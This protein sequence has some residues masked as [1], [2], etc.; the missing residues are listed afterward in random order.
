MK[1]LY[2]LP[3]VSAIPPYQSGRPI[4]A[5][6]R[7]FGLDPKNI[8]KL[9]SNE[10][11]LGCSPS[12]AK[13]IV[14]LAREV[15]IYPDFDSFHLRH[16]IASSVG[17]SAEHV[18]PAAGSSE[19]FALAAQTVLTA[20]FNAVIPRYSFQAY[21]QVTRAMGS[22]AVFVP[23][24]DWVPDVRA[25]IGAVNDL[26]RLVFLGT[27]NNPTGA[28]LS[29]DDIQHLVDAVPDQA[30]LLIDEA[31]REFLDPADQPDTVGLLARRRN[32]IVT[33]TFSKIYGLA[34]LRVG[35]ALGD[36]E[37]LKLLR[38]LQ[39]PFSVNSLAQAAAL[40]ALGDEEFADR[41]RRANS[42]ERA[43][44]QKAFD[45]RGIE[46]L[47]SGGNFIL[48]KAGEGAALARE[49]M[50]RGVIIRAVGNCDLPEWARVSVGLPEQNNVFLKQ[51]D[52]V[53]AERGVQV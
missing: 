50:Q 23:T 40:A 5:V 9:A 15:N 45:E 36:P 41:S 7:E 35:Y 16:A 12:V 37:L 25:M 19:I 26:T 2:P 44:L 17:V 51:L 20:E 43:R 8:V 29:Y 42:Q 47:P 49:L 22:N 31:Y 21:Q 11:P 4:D 10:N 34:G 13:K 28:V 52:E 39:P 48:F 24:R 33:R 53:L 30:L 46:H 27:P 18:L 6:A 32:V 3:H 14:D 1:S 38:R